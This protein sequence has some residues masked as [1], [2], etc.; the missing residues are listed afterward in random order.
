MQRCPY[1]EFEDEEEREIYLGY[2][3]RLRT[4]TIDG[5]FN[6]LKQETYQNT[7]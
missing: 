6:W 4:E 7:P 5:F 1:G 3:S 2:K